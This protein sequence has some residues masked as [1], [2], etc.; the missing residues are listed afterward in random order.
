MESAFLRFDYDGKSQDTY[1]AV[2]VEWGRKKKLYQ[3]VFR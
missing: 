2:V 1:K 3:W